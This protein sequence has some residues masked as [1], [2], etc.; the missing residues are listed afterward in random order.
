[1]TTLHGRKWK[2]DS[3]SR[4]AETAKKS[5]PRPRRQTRVNDNIVD[6]DDADDLAAW[7]VPDDDVDD[8]YYDEAVEL[9]P[10]P[11]RLQPR[12]HRGTR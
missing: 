5:N 3:A 10:P 7:L 12:R 4:A 2:K 11:L 8:E 1:M 9:F 6:V